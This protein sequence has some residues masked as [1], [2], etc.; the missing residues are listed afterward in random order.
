MIIPGKRVWIGDW[1]PVDAAAA[2]RHQ[3]PEVVVLYRSTSS[4][5]PVQSMLRPYRHLGSYQG[6]EVYVLTNLP[7]VILPKNDLKKLRL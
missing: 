5:R 7:A 1:N 6:F 3:A 2:I 4:Y